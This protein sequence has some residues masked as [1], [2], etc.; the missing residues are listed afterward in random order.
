MDLINQSSEQ[1]DSTLHRKVADLEERLARALEQIDNLTKAK[2]VVDF[3]HSHDVSGFSSPTLAELYHPN[4]QLLTASGSTLPTSAENPPHNAYP[5]APPAYQFPFS[6]M[7]YPY[8]FTS[9]ITVTHPQNSPIVPSMAIPVPQTIDTMI[10]PQ[11]ATQSQRLNVS[12]SDMPTIFLPPQVGQIPEEELRMHEVKTDDNNDLLVKYQEMEE[13]LKAIE[14]VGVSDSVRATSLCLI[15]D[16]IIPA[17]FK[18]PE[19]EKYSGSGDPMNHLMMYCSKMAAYIKDDKLLIHCFQF[20]LG[21]SASKWYFSLERAKVKGWT[22]L[23]DAF[24]K[25]Y[26]YNLDMMPTRSQLE[27]M[28]MKRG[29]SFREYAQRWRDIAAQ[30]IPALTDK[31]IVDLFIKTLRAPYYDKCLSVASNNF[32]DIVMVGERVDT[33]IRSKK[34]DVEES[35]NLKKMQ[36]KK[37]EGEVNTVGIPYQFQQHQQT[38]FSPRGPRPYQLRPQNVAPYRPQPLPY[39]PVN[40]YTPYTPPTTPYNHPFSPRP[41]NQVQNTSIANNTFQHNRQRPPRHY[42]PLPMTLTELYKQLF[43]SKKILPVPTKQQSPPF[44]KWF[45]P[46]SRCEYHS[47]VTGHSTEN[48]TT[49]KNLIQDMIDHGWLKIK[50]STPQ[51]NVN[52]NPL[53]THVTTSQ[54]SVNMVEM[55]NQVVKNVSSVKMSMFEIFKTLISSGL[56]KTVPP[57]SD[58]ASNVF[59]LTKSCRYHQGEVGHDIEGC[60]SFKKT[61]QNL[62][63]LHV[64][65]VEDGTIEAF[66]KEVAVLFELE[67][68]IPEPVSSNSTERNNLAPITIYAPSQLPVTSTRAVP[69]NYGCKIEFSEPLDAGVNSKKAPISIQNAS[70]D[71]VAGVGGMTRS[72]RCYTP[73]YLERQRKGKEKI[74]EAFEKITIDPTP[75][76]MLDD[77][78]EMK[79]Q[80]TNE[81]LNQFLKLMKQSEYSVVEQLHRTKAKISLLSLILHSEPHRDALLKVLN[82]AHVPPNV[83]T[84]NFENLVAQ[85]QTTNFVSF[86]D[87]EIDSEGTG[88]VKALHISVKCGDHHIAKVLIDNGSALNVMPKCILD[89]LP[90]DQSLIRPSN[91]IVK[92]FD[93]TRR[94]VIG[95]IEIPLMIGPIIFQVVMQVMDISPAYSILLGRPWIHSAGAVPSTLHQ[96]LKFVIDGHLVTINGEETFLVTKEVKAPSVEAAEESRETSF[97]SLELVTANYVAEGSLIPKPKVSEAL[98]MAG[99]LMINVDLEANS[100]AID[101]LL[102]DP[103]KDNRFGLGYKPKRG[104][105]QRFFAEKRE[106]RLALLEGRNPIDYAIKI[107]PIWETFHCPA[108]L[109]H[110][111]SFPKNELFG[112]NKDINDDICDAFEQLYVGVITDEE[113]LV[114]PNNESIC[115]SV[116]EIWVRLG[117]P[118]ESLTNWTIEPLPMTSI[119]K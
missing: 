57:L 95:T 58:V 54:A 76:Q 41:D 77:P 20:S 13:R 81:E 115:K 37:K 27:N 8:T 116:A 34:I 7:T 31:E 55:S 105:K 14:N 2:D 83:T 6:H 35:G 72:G 17:K 21:S 113:D 42:D 4:A 51:P 62:M 12:Q 19:F 75:E 90:V 107:P 98:K 88:H 32:A 117:A 101:A 24:L 28:E 102:L 44:P 30:I 23:A 63:T 46:N 45:D 49:L 103:I 67:V 99:R 97:Q 11:T 93:G 60:Q 66:S 106:K 114:R 70:I 73:E 94:D 92:A 118:G 40:Y 15:P 33:G 50:A 104:D 74:G 61:L 79:K 65:D 59:D 22:D 68:N 112:I 96:K 25:Q 29:E 3:T 18:M 78:R 69:W 85:I 110:Q 16:V 43:E 87:E 52:S 38:Y 9:P 53:P 39:N 82:E 26:G 64:I 10:A 1:D 111:P 100:L 108:Y 71:N 5:H 56:I 84:E 89:R 109:M 36:W 86:T 80:V 119:N 48:C 91:L 47:G